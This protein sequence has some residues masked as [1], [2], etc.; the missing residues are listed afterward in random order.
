MEALLATLQEVKTT[1]AT[2]TTDEDYNED[3]ET[4]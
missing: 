3:E 1:A 2:A 4:T